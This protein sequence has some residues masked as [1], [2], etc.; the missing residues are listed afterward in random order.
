VNAPFRKRKVGHL[1]YVPIMWQTLSSLLPVAC[2]DVLLQAASYAISAPLK[3]EKFYDVSGSLTYVSCVAV[4]LLAPHGRYAALQAAFRN[5]HPSTAYSTILRQYASTHFHSRQLLVSA[6][7]IL[8]ALRLG[9][10]LG[11]RVVSHGKDS[12][13]DDVKESPARFLPYWGA[14]AVWVF[15]TALPVWMVNVRLKSQ[16]APFGFFDYA[17]ASIWLGGFAMEVAADLQKLRWRHSNKDSSS[18]KFIDEGLWAHSRHPNY[19][20]KSVD[21]YTFEKC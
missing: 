19:F 3:T 7:T 18:K 10:F 20:G 17:G 4:S 13:F 12:R 1:F 11:Y 21:S 14:Q 2:A 16:H 6:T 15:L 5:A 8:W 9:T